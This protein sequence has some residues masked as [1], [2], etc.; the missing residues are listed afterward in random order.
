VGSVFAMSVLL[1]VMDLPA[2]GCI[3]PVRVC[4]GCFHKRD[5]ASSQESPR[6][7]GLSE[8]IH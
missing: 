4:D 2:L 7:P 8:F 1:R 3:K 6:N 5:G